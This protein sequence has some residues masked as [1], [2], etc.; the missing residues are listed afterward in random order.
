MGLI[1]LNY[2]SLIKCYVV[3][4][5]MKQKGACTH[6]RQSSPT[7]ERKKGRCRTQQFLFICIDTRNAWNILGT[8]LR[9]W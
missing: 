1:T 8:I 3:M 9:K 7:Y 4:R 2:G 5:K 6:V